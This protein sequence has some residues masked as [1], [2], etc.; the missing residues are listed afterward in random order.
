VSFKKLELIL[1]SAKNSI[2]SVF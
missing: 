2:V 1:A